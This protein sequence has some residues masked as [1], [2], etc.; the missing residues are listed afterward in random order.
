MGFTEITFLFLAVAFY[1]LQ[2]DEKVF[3]DIIL[4]STIG[5]K[6]SILRVF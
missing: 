3:S 6:A 2:E 1:D 4:H 5:Y